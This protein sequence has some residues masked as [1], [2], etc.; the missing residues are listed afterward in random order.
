MCIRDRIKGAGDVANQFGQIVNI[1]GAV[2]RGQLDAPARGV[3]GHGRALQQCDTRTGAFQQG[4]AGERGEQRQEDRHEGRGLA[5]RSDPVGHQ[6]I[7]QAQRQP[8]PL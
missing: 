3:Q 6:V 5:H 1:S 4:G 8:C 7:A 2:G